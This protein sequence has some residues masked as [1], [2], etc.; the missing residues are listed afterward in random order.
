MYLNFNSPPFARSSVRPP[1][2]SN[3]SPLKCLHR[4]YFYDCLYI[5]YFNHG[6]ILNLCI[7][8]IK[9]GDCYDNA[10]FLRSTHYSRHPKKHFQP[11]NNVSPVVKG[12]KW[13]Q[14][15]VYIQSYYDGI[16]MV[17]WWYYDIQLHWTY[18]CYIWN[19]S[20]LSFTKFLY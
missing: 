6:D 4:I 16:M 20:K 12:S 18:Q 13:H 3:I 1:Y 15:D 11:H 5:L 14:Y 7:N 8:S 19:N 2:F 9:T 10:H 17:L